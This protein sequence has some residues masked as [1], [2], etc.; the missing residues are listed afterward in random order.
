M[1]TLYIIN[2]FLLLKQSL[3]EKYRTFFQNVNKLL[4]FL[5]S[6]MCILMKYLFCFKLKNVFNGFV[7]LCLKMVI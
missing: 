6:D 2:L 1:F 3:N 5:F 7:Y 4:P